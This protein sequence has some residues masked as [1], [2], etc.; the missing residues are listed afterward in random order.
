[1]SSKV[2]VL[3]LTFLLILPCSLLYSTGTPDQVQST[4]QVNELKF[5]VYQLSFGKSAQGTPVQNEWLKVM[6]K[7]MKMKLSIP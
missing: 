1:M 7:Y 3:S 5:K 2:L 4:N 6:E